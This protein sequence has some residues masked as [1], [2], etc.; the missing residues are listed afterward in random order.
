MFRIDL[1]RTRTLLKLRYRFRVETNNTFFRSTPISR[2][3]GRGVSF[4]RKGVVSPH[5]TTPHPEPPFT[6]LSIRAQAS[7]TINVTAATTTIIG[8]FLNVD[9]P[10]DER[11]RR[12]KRAF[13]RR[14]V[15]K[16]S[17]HSS[18]SLAG[19]RSERAWGF[20]RVIHLIFRLTSIHCAPI[21]GPSKIVGSKRPIGNPE[22]ETPTLGTKYQMNYWN[23][24]LYFDLEFEIES[25]SFWL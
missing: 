18:W 5:P 19:Q 23:F 7:N 20:R 1:S 15:K 8:M 11:T 3:L 22:E 25:E 12:M 4:P 13:R 2:E 16:P 21:A 17:L 24:R 6:T 9:S 10:T 14:P